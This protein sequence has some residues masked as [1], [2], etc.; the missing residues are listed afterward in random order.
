MCDRKFIWLRSGHYYDH[1]RWRMR[2]TAKATTE[3]CTSSENR[4]SRRKAAYVHAR[5]KEMQRERHNHIEKWAS[6]FRYFREKYCSFLPMCLFCHFSSIFSRSVFFVCHCYYCW[7]L[8]VCFHSF[9][10]PLAF[11]AQM[12]FYRNWNIF[13][14]VFIVFRLINCPN[15]QYTSTHRSLQ[16]GHSETNKF[17]RTEKVMLNGFSWLLFFSF[18]IFIITFKLKTKPNFIGKSMGTFRGKN[19]RREEILCKKGQR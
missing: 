15:T 4:L 8:L 16:T 7:F 6:N 2:T 17:S 12:Y 5:G 13:F 10:H 9:L 11:D 3:Q 18:W 14:I 19:H 1:N